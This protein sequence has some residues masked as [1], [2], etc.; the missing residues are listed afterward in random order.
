QL[1]DKQEKEGKE[2]PVFA[3]HAKSLVID[4]HTTYIGTFNFDPRSANLN[5][6]V[7]LVIRDQQVARQVEQA[8]RL[9]MA[10]ENSWDASLP[11]QQG[12]GLLKRLKVGLW[13]LLPLRR[14]L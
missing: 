11:D 7:G 14:I 8:I 10:P 1:I 5:T 9:D 13:G 2:S 6:E 4:G 3:L 12:V